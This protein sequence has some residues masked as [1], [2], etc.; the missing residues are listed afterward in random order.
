MRGFFSSFIFLIFIQSSPLCPILSLYTYIFQ[1]ELLDGF[2]QN[3]DDGFIIIF[4]VGLAYERK[5]ELFFFL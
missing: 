1:V 3:Y 4:F 2:G 5:K